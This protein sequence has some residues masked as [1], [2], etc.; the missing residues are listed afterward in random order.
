[1]GY[2]QRLKAEFP[3]KPSPNELPKL[4]KDSFD[5]Y[6]S[7]QS[8]PF[9]EILLAAGGDN[10][11]QDPAMEI[12][13]P[14]DRDKVARLDALAERV[15]RAYRVP[16]DEIPIMIETA[17]ADPE[18]AWRSFTYLAAELRCRKVAM[19]ADNPRIKHA[20][21]TD[22]EVDPEHVIV[23]IGLRDKATCELAIPSTKYDP[24][25]FLRLA[26]ECQG[27]LNMS[28]TGGLT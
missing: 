2:L 21:I 28:K 4:P 8:R 23:T 12:R 17:K 1:M 3:E 5:S 13:R 16:D 22:T 24:F 14:L 10:L 27:A 9:A 6:D 15:A 26:E 19:L 11:L 18:H 20:I 7:S 25:L